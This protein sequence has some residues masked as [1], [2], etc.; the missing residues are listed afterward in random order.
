MKSLQLL[1]NLT[2]VGALDPDLR[3][4]D[5]IMETKFGTTYNSYVLKGKTKTAL[6]ET[7]KLKTFDQYIAKVKEVVDPKDVDYIIVNHTEPDH[8]GSVVK[9][10]EFN[11]EI[12]IIGTALA[13]EYLKEIVNGPFNYRIV[14]DGDTLDLGDLTLEFIMA[15]NLHWPDTMYTYVKETGVLFTCD[16][17][18]AHYCFDQVLL[19]KVTATKDYDEALKYYYDM[20]LGPFPSFMLKALDRIQGLDLKL[21]A[22]GHGPVID[23]RIKELIELTR[24]WATIAN[25]NTRKTVVIPYVSSY[26]YTE[27]LAAAISEGIQAAGDIEVRSFDLVST[28]LDKVAM[29]IF[30]ADGVLFGT[31]TILGDALK[32][33]WDLTSILY[34]VVHGGKLASA[35]GSYGWS[36]E[37]VPNMLARL[38]MLR[39]DVLD[40]L[41]IRFNPDEKKLAEA[42]AFGVTF[43]QKLLERDQVKGRL[44]AW[45]CILCGEIIISENR[46]SICPVCGAP[47]DQFIEIPYNETTFHQDSD[48]TFVI[49]GAGA[50]AVNAAEAIRIRNTTAQIVILSEEQRL[51]YNRPQLTK[52]FMADYDTKEFLLKDRSWYV[53]NNIDLRLGI[54]AVKID[55]NEKTVEL[56][57]GSTL[58][59]SKL[60]LSTG[61]SC[62]IPPI[63]GS[64]NENVVVIRNTKDVDKI[65]ELLPMLKKVIVIGGGILGLEAAWQFKKLDLEVVV[66]ELAP[67]L[68]TRQL[69]DVSSSRLRKIVEDQNIAVHTAVQITEISAENNWAKGVLLADGRFFEGD[70]VVVS[71]GVKANVDLAKEIGITI[72]RAIVVNDKMETN[73]KDIYAAGDCVEFA[74][75]NYAIWPQALEEGKVAGANAAGDSATY[76]G[77]IPA[78]SMQSLNTELYALGDPGKDPNKKYTI[79]DIGDDIH[80]ASARYFFT[81][82]GLVGGVLL[83]DMKPSITLIEGINNHLS[84][85]KFLTKVM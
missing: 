21:I 36:G 19:S 50:A 28:P 75:I 8:S 2:W 74:G 46:P 63:K 56:S 41:S 48:E 70:L 53:E 72:N 83:Y 60:I 20:I 4:F 32:P 84:P 5:I 80:H 6:I 85:E 11:P 33:L 12:E 17:F 49:V 73:L 26:G 31:P 37:G 22:P 13:I 78:V 24:G 15:P 57:D 25:P 54:K 47:A 62:F 43:G 77:V 82:A 76:S 38:T 35:F 61:A 9:L 68:M 23:T 40:G 10:L 65:K 39:M 66:L 42:K 29:E 27:K 64:I 30:Y 59:Y 16:S 52:D 1:P 81:E 55:P 45:K 18:G 3:T 67:M 79:I 58:H 44:R 34:P 51:V 7:A 14:T 69:D 71:A